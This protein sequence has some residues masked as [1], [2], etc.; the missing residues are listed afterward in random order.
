MNTYSSPSVYVNW[1]SF[2]S[3]FASSTD[4]PALQVRSTVFPVKKFFNFDLT[5]A[6]PFP[7]FTWR[8]STEF[9]TTWPSVGRDES[10][11]EITN[12]WRSKQSYAQLELKEHNEITFRRN[13]AYKTMLV[14]LHVPTTLYGC[15]S[16]SIDIPVLKSF[17]DTCAALTKRPNRLPGR[18][19][20]SEFNSVRF[21]AS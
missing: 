11:H 3:T 6:A 13:M 12:F 8:N 14:S 19:D 7:G 15:P 10:D 16:N 21:H 5:N 4:S 9:Y 17:D 1:L 18:C 20:R 2:L